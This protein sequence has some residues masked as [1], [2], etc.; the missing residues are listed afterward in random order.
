V[1]WDE[2]VGLT[3]AKLTPAA[4]RLTTL[5]G[6]VGDSFEKGTELLAEMAGIDLSE[7]TV[8][9]T[10]EQAGE[11]IAATLQEGKAFGPKQPWQWYCDALGRRVAYIGLDATGV[12]QQG[13]HGEKADGRMAHVGVIFNPL[14]D[15]ERG[16]VGRPKPGTA[17]QARYISGL[18]PLAEMGPLL[19][20]QGAQVGMDQADIWV[21][22]TDGGSGLEAFMETN[23][24]RVEAVILDFWHAT[25]Y[26][27]KLAKALHPRDED[28]AQEQTRAWCQLLKEEGGYALL[29]VLHAW[30]WPKVPGL[31]AVRA[32][33]LTYFENQKERMDYPSY[34]GNGWYIGSGV[35]ESA[36]KTVVGQRLKNA[37]MR[38][39]EPGSH[40]LCHVRALYRS[41][42]GQWQ[43]FWQRKVSP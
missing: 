29:G 11:R 37:G 8:Q 14:P 41:E 13:P 40:A 24:P 6:A 1:P 33:V 31:A 38:W 4:L 43:A 21:A 19:R 7:S 22:L 12:R 17:M 32:E 42:R 26:V 28:K 35:V 15:P 9:R 5:A 10:T 2:Q 36:C 23:F 20:R 30:D 18:Y 25:E 16:G 34:E 27:A 3:D 39:R